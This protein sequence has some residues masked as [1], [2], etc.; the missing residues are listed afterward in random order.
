MNEAL[1]IIIGAIIALAS[2]VVTTILQ[3][4]L[5]KRKKIIQDYIDQF[6]SFYNLEQLYVAEISCLR[7]KL[8]EDHDKEKTIKEE[9]RKKNE[10]EGYSHINLTA[11]NAE[12]FLKQF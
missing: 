8:G 5:G 7:Q 4:S 1:G 11:K 3:N 10:D 12:N 6:A 2:S 9:F